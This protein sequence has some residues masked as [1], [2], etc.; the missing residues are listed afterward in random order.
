MFENETND[1][2]YNLYEKRYNLTKLAIE[3]GIPEK[4]Y[5]SL[6][7]ED[8]FLN[9]SIKLKESGKINLAS[10][11]FGKLFEVTNNINALIYKI[12]CLIELGEYEEAQRYNNMAWELY[13]E[14]DNIDVFDIERRI[15]YQKALISFCTEKHNFT[16]WFCEECII[17]FK[18]QE[19]YHLLCANF[20]A[21]NDF[22][23]AKKFY[24]KYCNKFGDQINFLLEVFVNL[25]NLN[26]L[27]KALEF[28]NLIYN[29]TE[30][31][32]STIITYI[33]NY[34]S[35][36]KNKTILKTMFEKEVNIIKTL[37]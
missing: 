34:Y 18:T 17:K 30:K 35:F 20:I 10:F 24:S 9:L 36:N 21:L 22:S 23:N 26:Y 13:L 28:I 6:S 19:F 2:I 25:L 1:N 15:S 12:E 33:N 11:F 37:K 16:E 31:Q 3:S 27:E 8:K 7:S 14:Y 5:K 4:E 32:R 29:I